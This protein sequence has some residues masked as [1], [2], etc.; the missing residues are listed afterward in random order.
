MCQGRVLEAEEAFRRDMDE[1][2]FLKSH[3]DNIWAMSGLL[4]CL[5]IRHKKQQLADDVGVE[6]SIDELELEKLRG[7][8]ELMLARSDIVVKAAC[9]CAGHACGAVN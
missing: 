6:E 1:N 3:P 4:E 5:Q 2:F 7:K 8:V 9:L